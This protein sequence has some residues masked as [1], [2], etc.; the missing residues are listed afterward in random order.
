[1]SY[2]QL[3]SSTTYL[4]TYSYQILYCIMYG[5]SIASHTQTELG[6]VF[7][8]YKLQ[9]CEST[10]MSHHVTALTIARVYTSLICALQNKNVHVV[11]SRGFRV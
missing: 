3:L 4:Y 5:L 1:M 7:V 6:T 10:H 9:Y 2:A 11:V 8:K